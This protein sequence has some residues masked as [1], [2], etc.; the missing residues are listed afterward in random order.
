MTY[1]KLENPQLQFSSDFS[2]R[3]QKL[4]AKK[5]QKSLVTGRPDMTQP[6]SHFKLL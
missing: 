3:I 2:F 1:L 4:K 5:S 6:Y